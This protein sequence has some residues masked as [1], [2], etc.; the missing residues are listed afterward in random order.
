MGRCFHDVR[1]SDFKKKWTLYGPYPSIK[2]YHYIYATNQ[3]KH[4]DKIC[5][6]YTLINVY[7]QVTVI[8]V[9]ALIKNSHNETDKYTNVK[10]VFLVHTICHNSDILRSILIIFRQLLNIN[11]AYVE[12]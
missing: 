10:I 2:E 9:N 3:Q 8:T 4:I 12:M 11:K 5:L 1:F 7:Q 6:S